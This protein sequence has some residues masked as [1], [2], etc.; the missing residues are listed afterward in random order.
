MGEAAVKRSAIELSNGSKSAMRAQFT[1]VHVRNVEY[2]ILDEADR[3]LNVDGFQSNMLDLTHTHDFP[4]SEQRQTMLFSATFDAEV[5][6]FARQLLKSNFAFVSN[7]KTTS[8]NP[9]VQQNFIQVSKPE[10]LNKLCELLEEE[11]AKSGEVCRT[12]VFVTR[13]VSKPE[14]LNKLC[15][16]LEEEQAKSGEVCRT[17]VFVTRKVD[18]DTV[19]MYLSSNGIRACSIHGDREQDQREKALKEFRS[20]SVKVLLATDVCA[21]GIDVNNLEHV[22]NYDLPT[23]WIIYVHRIG[24]TGRMHAG[25][26]TSFIDPMEPHDRA[27]A[28]DLLRIVREV[29]QE[30]PQFLIDLAEGLGGLAGTTSRSGE[31]EENSGGG[32]FAKGGGGFANSGGGFARAG[33]GGGFASSKPN[34][35]GGFVGDVAKS[36]FGNA[37]SAR[38]AAQEAEA[39]WA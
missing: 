33:G 39:E 37:G 28:S 7:G 20:G 3:M 30:A 32:G 15:E 34:S 35:K 5:Q 24:R 4:T 11:Q 27:M 22:I 6:Q 17:L 36:G 16:L 9:R 8:A 19:A 18:T 25:K 12:L 29:Q 14:K 10:K 13:K 38:Q 23:E 21:R 2:F 26:A 31:T 1:K